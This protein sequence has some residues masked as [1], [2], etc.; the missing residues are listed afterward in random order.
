MEGLAITYEDSGGFIMLHLP[1]PTPVFLTSGDETQTTVQAKTQIFTGKGDHGP[2]LRCFG[3][4][5]RGG[6]LY[7]GKMG[8]ICH[9]PRACLLAYGDTASQVLVF[10]SIWGIQKGV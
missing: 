6:G 1:T 9:F 5:G 7:M 2:S 8:S 10:S 3:G 4:R